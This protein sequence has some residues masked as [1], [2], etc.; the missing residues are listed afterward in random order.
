MLGATHKAYKIN[1]EATDSINLLNSLDLLETDPTE[2]LTAKVETT[3]ILEPTGV[4][5]DSR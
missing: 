2:E 4:T 3:A 5:T 1:G